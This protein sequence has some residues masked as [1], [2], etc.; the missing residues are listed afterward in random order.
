VRFVECEAS[1]L[2]ELGR[3][4]QA[5][6]LLAPLAAI[7][8]G[9][10]GYRGSRAVLELQAQCLRARPVTVARVDSIRQVLSGVPQRCRFAALAAPYLP[11]PAALQLCGSALELAEGLGLRGHLPALLASQADAL[12]RV[13]RTDDAQRCAQ[14]AVRL[15]DATAP[16]T[17]R[18]GI[19]L[20]LHDTLTAM[21]DTGTA[22][23]VLLQASEWL[24]HTARKHVPPAFRDSFLGRNAVNRELLVRALRADIAPTR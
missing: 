11:P 21:G 20:L 14:R 23:E 3:G 19:W 15:L 6:R 1:I 8:G 24:H 22:R 16:L 17:Y 7:D 10:A 5:D 2:F 18:G 13:H 4:W 9:V 12:R